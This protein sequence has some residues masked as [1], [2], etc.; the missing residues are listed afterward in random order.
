MTTPLYDGVDHLHW[1][2]G[3]ALQAAAYFVHGFGMERVAYRGLETG[4]RDAAS[5]VV[6]R[7]RVTFVFTCAVARPESSGALGR[8]VS[9]H[10]Q[11]HGDGVHDVAL[12]VSDAR[13]AFA[14][15]VSRG[16]RAVHAPTELRE[17]EGEPVVVAT[18]ATY[19]ETVHTF[20]QRPA[21]YAGAFLPGVKPVP[22]SAAPPRGPRDPADPPQLLLIDHVVGNQP[23]NEMGPVAEWYKHKLDFERFWTPDDEITHTDMTGFRSVVVADKRRTVKLPINEPAAGAFKSQIQEFVDFYAGAGVQH[24][25]LLTGDAV[26]TVARLR[27]RG[28]EFLDAPPNYYALVEE[29]V[30]TANVRDAVRDQVRRLDWPRIRELHIMVDFNEEGYLLQIFTKPLSDRPTVFIEII[31]RCG[32]EGF[33]AG[34]FHALFKAVEMAQAKRGNL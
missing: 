30:R 26:E 24:I 6:R 17:D 27:A 14:Y 22:R 33:G 12:R 2:C 18:V 19:G 25:A 20:V 31:Q 8:E 11:R 10:V 9:A 15:A 23:A 34:N 16:A 29:R 28:V 32:C 21:S 1:Y 13:A 5:H 3:N 7:G 4:F